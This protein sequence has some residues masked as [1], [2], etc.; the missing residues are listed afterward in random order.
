MQE[1]IDQLKARYEAELQDAQE[2]LRVI[3]ESVPKLQQ[4]ITQ[5]IGKLQALQDLTSVEEET[6]DAHS[7]P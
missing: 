2:K 7:P 4:W 5:T 1:K 6:S 3:N